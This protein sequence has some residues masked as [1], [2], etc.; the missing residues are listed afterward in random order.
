MTKSK[1]DK[2]FDF[3]AAYKELEQ[4]IQ[5]FERDDVD[6][7]EGLRKFERGLD[8]AKRCKARLKDVENKVVEIKAKFGA[9]EEGEPENNA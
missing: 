1:S 9:L 7:E 4:I 3:G 6:L 2:G 8:L 5:W